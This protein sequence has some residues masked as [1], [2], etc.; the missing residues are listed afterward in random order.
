MSLEDQGAGQEPRSV[1]AIALNPDNQPTQPDQMSTKITKY[2]EITDN[3]NSENQNSDIFIEMQPLITTNSDT[4]NLRPS[5]DKETRVSEIANNDP[6]L[7]LALQMSLEDQGAGQELRSVEAIVLNPDSQPTQPDQMSTKTIKY[8]EIKDNVDS[9]N[10]NSDI[11]I[12]IH[13]ASTTNSD[14]EIS[15]SSSDKETRVSEIALDMP[16][17]K[18]LAN[19]TNISTVNPKNP[20]NLEISENPDQAP[21]VLSTNRSDE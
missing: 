4:L 19:N 14:A 10:L 16:P 13:P 7:D 6:D 18:E 12:E 8:S 17:S 15:R 21:S 2:S 5:S 1:E 3:V 20:E 11:V 9:E